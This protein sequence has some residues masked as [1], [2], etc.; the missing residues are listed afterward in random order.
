MIAWKVDNFTVAK[1]ET[2]ENLQEH[3]DLIGSTEVWKVA[4]S[5]E[6][7]STR[8]G[9]TLV[10]LFLDGP[11]QGTVVIHLNTTTNR[12]ESIQAPGHLSCPPNKS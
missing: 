5:F 1:I 3:V 6:L 12:L 10:H 2:C 11:G 4:A 7:S 9:V 8:L